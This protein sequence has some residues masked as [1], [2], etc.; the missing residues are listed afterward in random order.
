[1]TEKS[2]VL[3]RKYLNSLLSLMENCFLLILFV[4]ILQFVP[5]WNWKQRFDGKFCN[6]HQQ[7][8]RIQTKLPS[9]RS[10]LS[11]VASMSILTSIYPCIA[12]EAEVSSPVASIT[13]P[14][15]VAPSQ[16]TGRP[17]FSDEFQIDIP[18]T[19]LG[20]KFQ[21]N[22]VSGSYPVI[23]VK[24][25]LNPFLLQSHTELQIG[26][27]LTKIN[28]ETVNGLL[29][30]DIFQKIQQITERPIT[31]EFRDPNR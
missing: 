19:T 13:T 12:E 26:A 15:S 8:F 3:L 31:V 4:L 24:E 28:G 22:L 5:V 7:L 1:M 18:T 20:I 23:T 6:M 14:T 11:F 21:E 16:S 27:I 9:K 30:K 17:L 10:I 2:L 29:L 25:I